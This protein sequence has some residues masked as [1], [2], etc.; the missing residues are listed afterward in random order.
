MYQQRWMRTPDFAT[1]RAHPGWTGAIL[2]MYGCSVRAHALGAVGMLIRL[3][4]SLIAIHLLT[5]C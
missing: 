1:F 5:T 4:S 3:A 2:P